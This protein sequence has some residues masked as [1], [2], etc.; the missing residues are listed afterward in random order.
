MQSP[1]TVIFLN[2]TPSSGKTSI[3]RELEKFLGKGYSNIL[4]DDFLPAEFRNQLEAGLHHV[5][6]TLQQYS[7]KEIWQHIQKRDLALNEKLYRLVEQGRN[8]IIENVL[9]IPG[10]VCFYKRSL[11]KARVF[12]VGVKC[13]LSVVM[14]R[15]LSRGDRNVGMAKTVFDFV[16]QHGAY[17]LEVNSDVQNPEE[18]ARKIHS[19]ILQTPNPNAFSN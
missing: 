5:D 10:S 1:P 2:G 7:P 9:L 8:L 17:D 6:N 14:Q 19:F 3:A 13:P 18:C 11:V 15:E 4:A 12:F 16:H